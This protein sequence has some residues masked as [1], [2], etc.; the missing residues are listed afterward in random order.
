[1]KIVN[2]FK[3]SSSF[4]THERMSDY[5]RSNKLNT[6]E[7]PNIFVKEKLKQTNVR[8]NICNQY[9][10]IFKYSNIFWYIQIYSDLNIRTSKHLKIW[11]FRNLNIWTFEHLNIGTLNIWHSISIN[12]LLWH[13]LYWYCLSD[14]RVTLVTYINYINGLT[15]NSKSCTYVCIIALHHY[16][17]S[18]R[19]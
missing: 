11:K 14:L 1:M 2:I 6:N 16:K 9:I 18:C 17:S 8:I 10:R 4:Y 7:C 19:S 12:Q 13:Q 5:I 3:Y 15:E